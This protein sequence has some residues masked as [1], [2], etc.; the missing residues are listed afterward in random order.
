M[1]S[2][3]LAL[4]LISIFS[5]PLFSQ[6]TDSKKE[7]SYTAGYQEYKLTDSS[8]HYKSGAAKGN[9]LF[10]QPLEIDVWY[11]AQVAP[12]HTPLDYAYFV[13]LLERRANSF[14]DSVKYQGLSKEL[15]LHF[16]MGNMPSGKA[17]KTRSFAGITPVKGNFPLIIYFSSMN[18]MSY[19]NIPLFENLAS[20]GY[21][22]VAISSI[23]RY[24]GNMSTKFPD[25]MEQVADAEFALDFFKD[26]GIDTTKIGLAGYSYGGIAAIFMALKHPDIRTILSLDGSEKHYY[27]RDND[28]DKDFD[29]LRNSTNWRPSALKSAYAYL[30]SD[31]KEEESSADSVYSPSLGGV[32]KYAHINDAEHEDFSSIST[33]VLKPGSAYELINQLTLNYFD[34]TLKAS[35]QSFIDDLMAFSKNGRITL[36][37]K[38]NRHKSGQ[39]I[40]TGS[41]IAA[42]TGTPLPYASIGIPSGNR[43]TVSDYNG[44]FKLN[45]ADTLMEHTVRISALGYQSKTYTVSALITALSGKPE[46]RLH[47]QVNALNEVNIIAKKRRTRIVGNTSQSKFFKVGFPFKD[48]GSEVGI[49][50]SFGKKKVQLRSFNFNISEMRMDSCTFRLNIYGLKDGMPAENLL[51]QNIVKTIGNQPGPYT[52]DLESN[53]IV[54]DGTVFVSLEWIDGKTSSNKGMVFFSAGLLSSSYHRKTTEASWVK[55]KGLGAA[56]NLKVMED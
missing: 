27:G 19:E 44:H 9:P 52:I 40:L 14:Q 51:R 26:K 41:I 37:P 49:Q 2:K 48:L 12:N 6:T 23:G 47:E 25:I 33:P 5:T 4:L 42:A 18:G 11:P 55:F 8:R 31:H 43:G 15:S 22:V 17:I 36:S 13:S 3:T 34:Q 56:F 7:L 50:V 21:V 24:P 10:F 35:G 20:H 30:E 46:I 16:A 29:E 28:E 54:L 53:H 1:G 38:T 45:L 39:I 32:Y